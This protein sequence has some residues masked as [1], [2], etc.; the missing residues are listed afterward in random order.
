LLLLQSDRLNVT[1]AA[2]SLGYKDSSSFT[3]AFKRWYG[4]TP[5]Q[6]LSAGDL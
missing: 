3:K 5:K 2:L 6:Y 1:S 4:V